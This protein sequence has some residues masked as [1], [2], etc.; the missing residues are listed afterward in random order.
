MILS[1]YVID[2]INLELNNSKENIS[3]IKFKSV[4]VSTSKIKYY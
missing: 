1:G 2:S 3:E 4:T